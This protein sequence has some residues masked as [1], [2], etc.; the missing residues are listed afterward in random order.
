MGYNLFGHYH[1]AAD[2]DHF[3]GAERQLLVAVVIAVIGM[4]G[5]IVQVDKLQE[6]DFA[7][8]ADLVFAIMRHQHR[9]LEQ[10]LQGRLR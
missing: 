5:E 8:A 1:R 4:A 2:H 3:A 10:L 9:K 7:V 6:R